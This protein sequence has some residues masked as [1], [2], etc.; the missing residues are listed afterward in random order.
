LNNQITQ[1]ESEIDLLK[2][3]LK[4]HDIT[5][6]LQQ[7]DEVIKQLK[8]VRAQQ[9]QSLAAL[10]SRGG[11][12]ALETVI[13]RIERA[14]EGFMVR[15]VTVGFRASVEQRLQ[16]VLE[17]INRIRQVFDDQKRSVDKLTEMTTTQRGLIMKLTRE[18]SSLK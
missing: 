13:L 10:R 12:E 14:L 8:A 5:E 18:G 3:Q 17:L 2:R 1:Q 11:Q 9:E 4:Q 16:A 15:T 7:K 6:L